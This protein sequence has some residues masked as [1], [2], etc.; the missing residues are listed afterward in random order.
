ME[1]KSLAEEFRLDVVKMRELEN[2]SEG[3]VTCLRIVP[4]QLESVTGGA[5]CG[6]VALGRGRPFIVKSSQVK[7]PFLL[8]YGKQSSD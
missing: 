1:S 4:V 8:G 2:V 5:G 6:R 3:G 7:C